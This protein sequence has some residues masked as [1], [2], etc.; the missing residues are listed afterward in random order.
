MVSILGDHA[1]F[2][3]REGRRERPVEAASEECGAV[4][5]CKFVVHVSW[6]QI[7][8]LRATLS[9]ATPDFDVTV[10]HSID[11]GLCECK[12]LRVRGECCLVVGDQADHHATLVSCMQFGCN[13]L[14]TQ[15][16]DAAV[17]CVLCTRKECAQLLPGALAREEE[18]RLV[19]R[20]RSQEL[21]LDHAA[22]RVQQDK[23]LRSP[24]LQIRPSCAQAWRGGYSRPGGRSNIC[25][26][27]QLRGSE[28]SDGGQQPARV[29]PP[30][31]E[32]L[33]ECAECCNAGL[34]CSKDASSCPFKLLLA[35]AW[36]R[37]TASSTR[38]LPRH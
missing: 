3:I 34:G 14:I 24:R 15:G 21:L 20:T 26:T 22:Q 37:R 2:E 5:D 4:D 35:H 18:D 6:N 19:L 25:Q 9:M 16:E 33:H 12:N 38:V 1:I 8:P 32:P 10:D 36:Q 31:I 13:A 27:C 17:E 28:P 7:L 30:W 29:R 23:Q 11:A